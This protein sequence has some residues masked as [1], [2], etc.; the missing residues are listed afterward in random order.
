MRAPSR[1]VRVILQ[2]KHLSEPPASSGRSALVP[3]RHISRCRNTETSRRT[4]VGC[5]VN[6]FLL[7]VPLRKWCAPLCPLGPWA[8][9]P[10][11]TRI[12][13]LVV[14]RA[15]D[16]RTTEY[17]FVV[18]ALLDGRDQCRLE[19]DGN[20]HV[21]TVVD[22]VASTSGVELRVVCYSFRGVLMKTAPCFG[23]STAASAG[24]WRSSGTAWSKQAS[25]S[26]SRETIVNTIRILVGMHNR[27][28]GIP[29][30]TRERGNTQSTPAREVHEGWETRLRVQLIKKLPLLAYRPF[31]NKR[32]SL[33]I[34]CSCPEGQRPKLSSHVQNKC[35]A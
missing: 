29:E 25:A 17:I 10:F 13:D 33:R 4:L 27:A 20:L 19:G 1:Q 24:S 5:V 2:A 14:G 18:T 26:R 9:M 23:P 6:D 15:H 35:V 3:S 11:T 8:L 34:R 30:R 22:P 28:R 12:L 21:G 16:C 32:P 7:A 31:V